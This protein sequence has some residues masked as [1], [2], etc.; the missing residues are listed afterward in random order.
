MTNAELKPAPSCQPA[1]L[2]TL[3]MIDSVIA[4]H[5][6]HFLSDVKIIPLIL[7]SSALKSCRLCQLAP[8]HVQPC[9]SCPLASNN[10]KN[11][12]K[13]THF[14]LVELFDTQKVMDIG[15][16]FDLKWHLDDEKIRFSPTFAVSFS[17]ESL[18]IFSAMPFLHV[19]RRKRN[20]KK[21]TQQ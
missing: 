2:A 17:P 10:G 5:W 16:V 12:K 19:P 3:G 8:P 14:L 7:R 21:K 4:F 6:A 13:R 9:C 15:K 20:Q 18:E 11:I 1:S